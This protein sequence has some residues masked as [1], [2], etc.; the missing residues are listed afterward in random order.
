MKIELTQ[1]EENEDGSVNCHVDMDKQAAHHLINYALVNMLTT[2]AKE[3]K[4]Y[5]P[6]LPEVVEEIEEEDNTT[7]VALE[8]EQIDS[9]LVAE[10]KRCLINTYNNNLFHKEDIDNN[11]RVRTA[12]KELLSYYMIPSEADAYLNEIAATYEC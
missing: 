5:T 8:T 11:I 12:C 7:W 2:A 1:Y 3:G 9:I 4:L 6:E 10:L